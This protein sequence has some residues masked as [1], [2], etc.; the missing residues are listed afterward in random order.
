MSCS[1]SHLSLPWLIFAQFYFARLSQSKSH[2]LKGGFMRPELLFPAPIY[3]G[4]Q[5]FV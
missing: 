1:I 3:D 5:L 4:D 2:D